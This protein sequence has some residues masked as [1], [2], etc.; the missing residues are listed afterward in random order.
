MNI[1]LPTS[2]DYFSSFLP[3]LLTQMH[4]AFVEGGIMTLCKGF[5]RG[6][7]LIASEGV[8]SAAFLLVLIP[9]IFRLNQQYAAG[10]K[11][12][13]FHF[14]PVFGFLAALAPLTPFFI[15]ANPWFS[16]RNTAASFLGLGLIADYF[17]RLIFRKR[18]SVICAVFAS[19]CMIASVSE[20][21]D[22]RM[23]A[24]HNEK[25][26][27]T[28]IQA[29]EEYDLKGAVG[30]LGLNESYLSDQNYEYHDHV[31]GSHGSDWALE[32]LLRYYLGTT[33]DYDPCP[34]SLDGEYYSV[35]WNRSIKD[36]TRFDLLLL[37]DHEGG[38]IEPLRL[39]SSQGEHLMYDEAGNLRVRIW[40]DD[41]GDVYSEVYDK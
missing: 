41:S 26:A 36:V 37:Y 20:L 11:G 32:G 30:I 7:E 13:L 15:I 38:T 34:L 17:L 2:P 23:T 39:D 35:A 3:S 16:L 18:T 9:L 24:L 6:V 10:E 4:D 40:E 1:V 22:Y 12:S 31:L 8:W 19:V 29:D 25:V 28:I 33:I 21:Y 27:Q 14:A 5:V